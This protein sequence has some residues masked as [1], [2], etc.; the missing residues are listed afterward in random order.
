ME[1]RAAELKLFS[2]LIGVNKVAVVG[3]SHVTLDVINNYRLSVEPVACSRRAVSCV[4][5]RHIAL[6]ETRKRL[7]VQNLADK[8][9]ILI[10]VKNSVIVDNDSAAFLTSVL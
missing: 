8:A 3:K 10:S 6:A 1:N 5:Y 2:Q 9:D 4:G 7:S